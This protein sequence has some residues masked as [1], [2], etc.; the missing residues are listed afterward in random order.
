MRGSV[1]AALAVWALAGPAAA[2]RGHATL[3]VVEIDAVTGL[4]TIT[5]LLTA[6]DVEPA[7]SVIAPRAQA[8]VD[9]P[10]AIAALVAY[11]GWA[12]RLSDAKGRPVVLKPLRTDLAGDNVTLVYGAKLPRGTRAVSV[13]SNLFEEVYP[14]QENQVNVRARK[15]TK[16]AVFRAGDGPQ[17]IALD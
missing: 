7:L 12:F 8:S 13:D 16:T 11:A 9:D 6:H 3:S 10:D 17:R 2:H 4:V 5:H 15:V 1:L 14:D